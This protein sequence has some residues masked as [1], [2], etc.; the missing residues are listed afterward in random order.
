[1]RECVCYC[2]HHHAGLDLSEDALITGFTAT[3]QRTDGQALPFDT[4]TTPRGLAWGLQ[5]GYLV[6]IQVHSV[7]SMAQLGGAC[8]AYSTFL[9]IAL[10]NSVLAVSTML[11]TGVLLC[12][13]KARRCG[14][15]AYVVIRVHVAVY[16]YYT[17]YILRRNHTTKLYTLHSQ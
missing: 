2:L 12:S 16:L 8:N 1:V 3:Q 10:C 6:D 4:C 9:Y 7:K 13:L 17:L 14:M 15:H 5:E 11:H